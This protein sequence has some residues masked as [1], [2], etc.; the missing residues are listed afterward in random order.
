M[1]YTRSFEQQP[2]LVVQ[3]EQEEASLPCQ[4]SIYV[5]HPFCDCQAIPAQKDGHH[6][7]HNYAVYVLHRY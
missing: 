1:D 5:S 4:Q 3:T 6:T 2:S 7:R